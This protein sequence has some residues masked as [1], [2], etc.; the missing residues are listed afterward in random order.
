M[1]LERVDSGVRVHT[2]EVAIGVTLEREL[3]GNREQ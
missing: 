3:M 2:A 1:S